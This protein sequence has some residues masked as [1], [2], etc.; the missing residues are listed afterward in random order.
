MG[1]H[2]TSEDRKKKLAADSS[3]LFKEIGRSGIYFS[4][5]IISRE[6]YNR[7]LA[8]KTGLDIFNKMR[9][10][11]GTVRA[12]LQVVKLP[13][14]GANWTIESASEEPADELAAIIVRDSLFDRINFEDFMREL[15]TFLDF[16][17]SV[18]EQCFTLGD[19]DGKEYAVLKKLGFRKQSTIHR[20]EMENGEPGITQQLPKGGRASIPD[21]KLTKF[22]NEKEGDNWEGVSILRAA[23]RHW[24]VKDSLYKIDAVAHEK[25][26]LGVPKLV[27]PEGARDED[28]EEA[29]E[30]A[31]EARANEEGF[32]EIPAGFEYEFMDMKQ[33][34]LRDPMKSISH[35]NRQ[36]YV[37]VLAQFLDIGSQGSSGSF[38]ASKDQ[39]P[40]FIMSLEA[41]AK[42]IAATI[43]NTIIKNIIDLNGLGVTE[44]PKLKFTK[45]GQDDIDK[46]TKSM[47][48]LI[49][50]GAITME[51][52]IEK[53]VRTIM[54]L[55]EMSEDLEDNYDEKRKKSQPD[56]LSLLTG[57][58]E[59][60]DE[61]ET[62]E[63]SELIIEAKKLRERISEQISAD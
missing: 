43:N 5:G 6:E 23:Y 62:K 45:I 19:I 34:G 50:S 51:S 56:L 47:K 27:T 38:A 49:D 25:H 59:D 44:Y 4:A 21:I 24:Y 37:N 13:I 1:N 11:D 2:P 7:K 15:L 18:F 54:H 53:H 16:G 35:H 26:G 8:G 55:P 58:K 33:G 12:S 10:S 32:I 30:I 63:A 36:I 28:K 52:D 41:M 14:Q 9:K 17:H 40:F 57:K 3:K 61:D 29:R 48:A 20:W 42:N 22:V 39:S 60:E 31:R 46:F